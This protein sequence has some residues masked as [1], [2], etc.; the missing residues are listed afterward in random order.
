MG[1]DLSVNVPS[2]IDEYD[3]LAKKVGAALESANLNVLYRSVF[4]KFRSA[5]A[6]A[7]ENNSGIA[8][9][10]EAVLKADGTPKVDDETKEPV[11]KFTETEDKYFK[12]ACAQLAKQGAFA[13]A[14]AAAASFLPLAQ[15]TI[16]TIA[17]DPSESERAPSG[18]K[19][20]A[21]AYT[22]LAEQAQASGKLETLAMQLQEKLGATWYVEVTIDSVARAV[23]EDQRRKRE[24]QSLTAEYAV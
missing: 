17:F 14:E 4:A 5:F 8:R 20:V 22:K 7:V 24:A 23:S 6:E 21:K 18:P 12:R 13:S 3:T 2:S 19:T 15:E 9:E 16:A 11:L 1:F 10:T